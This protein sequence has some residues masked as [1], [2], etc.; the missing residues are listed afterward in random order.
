MGPPALIA[1]RASAHYRRGIPRLHL[2]SR[3]VTASAAHPEIDLIERNSS[4]SIRDDILWSAGNADCWLDAA[5]ATAL[6]GPCGA[7]RPS[8]LLD[9]ADPLHAGDRHAG[10]FPH[11]DRPGP[12]TQP[13][14]SR[15]RL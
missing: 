13:R 11:R 4:F 8:V 2:A 5:R 14:R 3:P 12:D 1:W 10:L 7:D 9:H 6:R 15:R